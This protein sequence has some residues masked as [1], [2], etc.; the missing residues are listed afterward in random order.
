MEG[1]REGGRQKA[2]WKEEETY[3]IDLIFFLNMRKL[4]LRDEMPCSGPHSNKKWSQD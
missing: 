4:K 1:R 3:E 2:E